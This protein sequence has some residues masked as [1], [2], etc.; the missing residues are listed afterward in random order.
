MEVQVLS[1]VPNKEGPI[2]AFF[3]WSV[4]EPPHPDFLKEKMIGVEGR[5]RRARTGACTAH[6]RLAERPSRARESDSPLIPLML[7]KLLPPEYYRCK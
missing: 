2:G 6:D 7:V 4:L 3:V 5:R 1:R